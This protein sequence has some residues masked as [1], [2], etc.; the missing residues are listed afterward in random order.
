V[1]WGYIYCHWKGW[2][3]KLAQY[4][5]QFSFQKPL[6]YKDDLWTVTQRKE[7]DLIKCHTMVARFQVDFSVED[8]KLHRRLFLNDILHLRKEWHQKWIK[9]QIF[10]LE[11]C[12]I[13]SCVVTWCGRKS[14]M[15]HG[16]KG[17]TIGLEKNKNVRWQLLSVPRII[18]Y[19]IILFPLQ[20]C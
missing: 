4:N 8:F 16:N 5:I 17:L 18:Y 19:L 12:N 14:L 2:P 15:G 20:I 10:I 11:A 1:F 9:H 13:L 7:K 6:P 3:Q